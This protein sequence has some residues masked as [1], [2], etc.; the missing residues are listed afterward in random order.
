MTS[1]VKV[2]FSDL[3][4]VT[5]VRIHGLKLLIICAYLY[6]L[7]KTLAPE[8]G[9]DPSKMGRIFRADTDKHIV[10]ICLYIV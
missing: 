10:Y 2:V 4:R 6:Q 5:A 7:R 8:K 9:G 3:L 1:Q